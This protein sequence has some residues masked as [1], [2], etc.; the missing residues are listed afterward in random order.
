VVEAK[1][2]AVDNR[3]RI[4]I[5]IG[6]GIARR[7]RCQQRE[8]RV[9]F[10]TGQQAFL[11]G[12]DLFSSFGSV[13]G[14]PSTPGPHRCRGRNRD[15]DRFRLCVGVDPHARCSLVARVSSYRHDAVQQGFTGRVPCIQ[16]LVSK[17]HLLSFDSDSDTD[18][19]PDYNPFR[20]QDAFV[21]Y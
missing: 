19:D 21:L 20:D 16:F 17:S 7:A 15:R 5:E 2:K 13:V 12:L 3:N 9:F 6:I 11:W 1:S 4:G 8:N 10:S 18:P 14:D